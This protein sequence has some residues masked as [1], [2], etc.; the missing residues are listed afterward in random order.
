M[1]LSGLPKYVYEGLVQRGLAPIAASGY[2]GNMKSESNFKPSVL[3][4]NGTS[5]GLNQWRGDRRAAL[6]EL[7]RRTGRSPTDVDVQLDHLVNEHRGVE[8][9]AGRRIDAA[10]TPEEAAHAV[11]KYYERPAA[12]ALASSLPERTSFA[13]SIFDTHGAGVAG[14][15]PAI[16]DPAHPLNQRTSQANLALPAAGNDFV[17]NRLPVP[18]RFASADAALG[19]PSPMTINP[20]GA[21]GMAPPS[22]MLNT[23]PSPVLP[24]FARPVPTGDMTLPQGAPGVLGMKPSDNFT[25]EAP[26]APSGIMSA[27]FGKGLGD[28][29]KALGGGGKQDQPMQLTPISN[30]GSEQMARMG[31]AQNLLASLMTMQKMRRGM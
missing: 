10:R 13:R 16:Q 7:A 3:G 27:D 11:A 30:Y 26:A 2:V 15:P 12:S 20:V 1:N 25:P 29:A 9:D 21:S 14:S 31:Q 19:G 24:S 4:D 22:M 23:P 5:I 17:S 18:S 8:R 28:M 6:N